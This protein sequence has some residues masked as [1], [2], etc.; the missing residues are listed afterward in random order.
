VAY[1]L[2]QVGKPYVFGAAG[3]DAFDCS[4]L[5]MRAW[6]A[7]GVSLPHS[8]YSMADVGTRITRAQLRPGDLVL[9][10]DWGHVQLYIGN[11]NIVEAPKPGEVV[12]VRSLPTSGINAYVR[13]A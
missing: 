2:R 4:G 10:Y 13:V 5:V 1:A 6:E 9:L 7:A 8:T 12:R 11:G 3:P